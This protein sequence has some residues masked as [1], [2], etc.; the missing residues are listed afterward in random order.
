MGSGR[1]LGG[2]QVEP[3]RLDSRETRRPVVA[4]CFRGR[5]GDSERGAGAAHGADLSSELPS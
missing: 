2:I 4:G 5:R 3:V 1:G